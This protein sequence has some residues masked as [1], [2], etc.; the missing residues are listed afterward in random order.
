MI[1]GLIDSGVGGFSILQAAQ[2]QLPQHNYVYLADQANFPYSQRST[3]NLIELTKKH[4][5]MLIEKYNCSVIVLACNTLSVAALAAAR[6]AFPE[7]MFVGTVPPIKVAAETLLDGNILVLASEQTARSEYL[8]QLL[9]NF[10]GPNWEV[11]GSTELVKAIEADNTTQIKS[12]L[13][14]IRAVYQKIKF[15]GIVLGC[16]HFPLVAAEIQAIWPNAKLFS[17]SHGVVK[18]LELILSREHSAQ[19][20]VQPLFLATPNYSSS[21]AFAERYAIYS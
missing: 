11:L 1:I 13:S 18:Q 16:T 8:R 20:S 3:E 21:P 10:P 9:E 17:P 2:N 6:S 14:G 15:S 4:A 5:R 7:I 12:V 19:P